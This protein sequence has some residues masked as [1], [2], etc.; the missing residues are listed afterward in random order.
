MT[1]LV[2]VEFG[3]HNGDNLTEDSDDEHDENA[4]YN[5]T[6]HPIRKLY[7]NP[8]N[9]FHPSYADEWQ[10]TEEEDTNQTPK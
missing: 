3:N 9:I 8:K 1:H 5:W 6:N 7:D 10:T 4:H 2:P